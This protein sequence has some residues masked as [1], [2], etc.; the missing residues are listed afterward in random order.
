LIAG[1]LAT[2]FDD[3]PEVREFIRI[4][5]DTD[6]QCAQGSYAGVG[7]ISPNVNTTSDCYDNEVVATSAESTLNALREGTARFDASDLMP[8]QVG[9]GSFWTAMNEWMRGG[10]IESL[11]SDVQASWP[12]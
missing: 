8:P 3:R 5:T 1:E 10:D 2:V 4:F 9:S 6:A 11:L 7:R 12:S